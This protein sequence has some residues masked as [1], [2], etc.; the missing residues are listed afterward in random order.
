MT[1][2]HIRLMVPP[3]VAVPRGVILLEQGLSA[4]AAT[5]RTLRGAWRS[6]RRALRQAGARRAA[7]ELTALAQR[8]E[9]FDAAVARALREAA[10]DALRE[11]SR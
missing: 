3:P 8:H 7:R 10:R 4:A 6:V 5:G 9:A 1:T 2:R 11:S